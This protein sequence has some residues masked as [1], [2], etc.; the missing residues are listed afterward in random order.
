MFDKDNKFGFISN[1]ESNNNIEGLDKV[2]TDINNI[3]DEVNELNTQYKDIEN[4]K[5]DKNDLQTQKNRIDNLA[6]LKAGSTTGDAELIDGRIGFNG[7]TYSNIGE[8]IRSQINYLNN[9]MND[10]SKLKNEISFTFKENKVEGYLGKDGNI[11]NTDGIFSIYT[12]SIKCN[13]GDVFLYKGRGV[14]N[15][16]VC[17]FKKNGVVTGYK[18]GFSLNEYIEIIIPADVNE[19]IF[20]SFEYSDN[21]YFEL[22][23]KNETLKEKIENLDNDLVSFKNKVI[24]T[25]EKNQSVGYLMTNGEISDEKNI[26]CIYTNDIDCIPGDVFLYKGIGETNAASCLFKKDNTIVSYAQYNSKNTYTEITIP[27][28]VNKVVFGSFEYST[29]IEDIIFDLRMKNATLE[30]KI[31]DLKINDYTSSNILHGKKWFACGDSFTEGDFTG[32]T[33]ENGLSGKNSPEIYDSVKGMYKTYPWWIAGRNNMTLINEAQCGTYFTNVENAFNPFSVS[34]YKAVPKDVDYITL[35]FG[36]NESHLSDEQIGTKTD[37]TN[38]TLCGA[39]NI[40]F[41]YFLR[42]VPYA[43]I[44]VIISDAWLPEKYANATIEICKYWGV[45]YLNLKGD[46]NITMGIGGKFNECSEVART[47]RDKA[48]KVTD[49][50]EHPNVKAHEFRSTIIENFLRSL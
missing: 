50:N 14:D 18:Q 16:A 29:N 23:L 43:K 40:V 44:G 1:N 34:R 17:V 35:M 19:V 5:A 30:D 32:Y 25:F 7:I 26:V 37:T 48:F 39:Y 38:T 36:L 3:K 49:T 13:E 47:L 27:S 4:T 21:V 33:D 22:K 10:L 28:G 2:K 20:G 8:S 45:P 46:D 9:N 41:E 6:T 42:N 12:N 15:G 24:F 31:N 11:I